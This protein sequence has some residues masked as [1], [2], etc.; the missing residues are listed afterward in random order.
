MTKPLLCAAAFLICH[1]ALAQQS[2]V[3]DA[4]PAQPV[5]L[6]QTPEQAAV[7][8]AV[9]EEFPERIVGDL[10][11]GIYRTE[12]NVLGKRS[13]ASLRPYAYF[14]YGRFFARVDTFGIKTAKLGN[15]YLELAAR[16]TFD[17][18][19]SEHGLHQRSSAIPLGI[20]TFQE[21]SVGAFF[22][23]AFYDVNQSRGSLLEAVYAAEFKLGSATFYPQIG[24]ERRSANYNNYFYGVTSNEALAGGNRY[25]AYRAGA[26]IDPMLSLTLELP[27]SQNWVANLTYRRKWL[28]AAIAESPI[29]NRHIENLGFVAISYR[30]K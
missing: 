14:D 7:Q 3:Q 16:A 1:Q 28:G 10:G 8:T 30:F 24:I 6:T 19:H 20:G 12:R 9:E 26:S 23:N 17:V 5:A 21:T 15:G 2:T 22:L 4:S 13:S 25:N 18:I 29:V 27:L 11:V